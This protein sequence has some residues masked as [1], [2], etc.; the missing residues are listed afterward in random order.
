VQREIRRELHM[1]RGHRLRGSELATPLD[2]VHDHVRGDL[3]A[4]VVVV[5]YGELGSPGKSG[6][7]RAVREKLRTLFDD[8]TV[9]LGFRHFPIID[10]HP[11][12][13]VA[14]LAVEAADRQDR[15]WSLHDALTDLQTGFWAKEL[16]VAAILALARR[17]ELD[18][19]RLEADIDEPSIAAKILGDLRGGIRSGVN[20]APTFYVQ[21]IRQDVDG[22]DELLDRIESALTGDYA[23]LWPPVHEPVHGSAR[24]RQLLD[25]R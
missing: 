1:W 9:C 21:G 4:P 15:F 8:G 20:G 10:G 14:A 11:G 2:P 7:E 18:V 24:V 22:A 25:A 12:A 16:D 23:A 5:E 19:A 17:I 3:H 6:E 13:W